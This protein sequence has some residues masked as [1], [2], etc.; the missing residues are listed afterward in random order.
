MAHP[1]PNAASLGVEPTELS[2]LDPALARWLLEGAGGPSPCERVI[3]TSLSLVFLFPDRALKLKKSVDYDFVDFSTRDKRDT[4]LEREFALNQPLAPDIY[5]SV[6]QIRRGPDGNLGLEGQGEALGAVL[7]MRR[8]ADDA[9]LSA[10]ARVSGDLGETLGRRIARF[11]LEASLAPDGGGAEGLGYVLA[12]NAFQLRQHVN[13]PGALEA[14]RV[15]RLIAAADAALAQAAPQLDARRT[16][17][18]CRACHGDLHTD[19]IVIEEGRVSLI[20]GIE[21]NDRLREIDILY[22]LA[23]LIM[24]LLFRGAAEAASRVLNGW[25]DAAARAFGAELYDG[26]AVLPLFLA[27]R[28]SVRAH[29]R[30]REGRMDEARAYLDAALD[31]LRAPAPSLLA[32][33]GAQGSGKS[34]LARRLAPARGHPPGAVVL[35]SDEIRKRLM[36]RE[37]T[38]PLP[39]E[40]YAPEVSARVYD[41]LCAA[42]QASLDAGVTVIADAVFYGP[43]ERARIE[44]VARRAGA[45]F[46]GVWLEVDR[47]VAA[48]RLAARRSDASDADLAVREAQ[49]SRDPGPISW[50][51]EEG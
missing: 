18:F 37:P 33:G 46:E 47:E 24:D 48:A 35:R 1:P 49:L 3:E 17:G 23:F 9:L 19:N 26:L 20:D 8:F 6:R 11:H 51:R 29:V 31:H 22:D 50:R 27:T 40:A 4:A 5:R 28:A 32:I 36:G 10:Q 7:E 12:S 14:E 45:P 21:F 34:H 43:D 2:C 42:T 15:E 30:A 38:A 41:A 16:Q 44:A 13:T 39:R 25:L